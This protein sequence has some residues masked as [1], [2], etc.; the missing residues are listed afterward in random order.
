[1][2]Y[3]RSRTFD[4]FMVIWTIALG[5]AIP[6]LALARRPSWVR[7]FSR[8]WCR[9]LMAGLKWIVGLTYEVIGEGNIPKGPAFFVCNHQS[10][11]ETLAASIVIPD[12]AIV[13]KKELLSVPIFGW[14]LKR[15]PMILINRTAGAKS[16]REMMREASAA[17]AEGRSI[18]IFGEGTRCE[19][20]ERRPF[21]IG[22]VALYQKLG[23]PIVPM[24]VN[25]GLFWDNDSLMKY[26][27]K[28]IVSF[29]PQLSFRPDASQAEVL[30]TI[31]N[32]VQDEK[33]RL[34]KNSIDG[35]IDASG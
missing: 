25:A 22:V 19:V 18:L 11:W 35:S 7:L 30:S 16:L 32:V 3:I 27:G 17:V 13:I 10:M 31:Q 21:R 20:N 5:A 28:V 8:I 23:I 12:V 29:L 14:Y 34:V 33:D 1:M 6:F 4:V 9:G 2:Q 26:G 15:S 24:A